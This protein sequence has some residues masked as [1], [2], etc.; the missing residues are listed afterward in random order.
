MNEEELKELN[1][2]SKRP[3][4]YCGEVDTMLFCCECL[5]KLKRD[6][7]NKRNTEV[8]QMIEDLINGYE[9]TL[10]CR[11]PKSHKKIFNKFVLN[12]KELLKE[13]GLDTKEDNSEGEGK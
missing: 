11:M 13:L 2:K 3:C 1:K 8:K 12:L 7:V 9:I 6:E 10:N 4:G 5:R